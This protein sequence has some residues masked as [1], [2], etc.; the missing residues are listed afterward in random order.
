MKR[1]IALICSLVFILILCVSCT[2]KTPDVVA[3][4]NAATVSLE[5]LDW[6]I[7]VEI[8]GGSSTTYTISQAKDHDIVK[9]YCSYRFMLRDA[10]D[11][12]QVTTAI[13]EG[14][15]F[16]D[17]L[18]DI[19]YPDASSV[20]IYHTN[21]NYYKPRDF[22]YDLIHDDESIITWIQNKKEVIANSDSYVGFASA[23]G[24]VED[25]CL[26]IAKIVVHP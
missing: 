13:F 10:T 16:S 19:G 20:T 7:P 12:P 9:I 1:N 25:V 3:A 11:A 23:N 6:S 24:A 17:F 18:A 26:S 8:D 4:E 14:V 15:R 22:D 2:G 5:T 21:E